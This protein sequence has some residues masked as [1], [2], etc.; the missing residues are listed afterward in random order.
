MTTAELPTS[1]RG[2][3]S[4][5]R[6]L[7]IR[8]SKGRGQNFLHDSGVVNRIVKL[9]GVTHDDTVVEIGP[10]LGILT[11]RLAKAARRV[12]AI[13]ID[14]QLARHLQSSFAATPNVEILR[15]DAMS[16]E[17][18]DVAGN[19]PLR[20]VANLPYS[21]AAAI[22]Q[23][24]LESDA[25]LISATFMLQR[26]VGLRMLAD[27]PNMSILGVATQLYAAGSIGFDVPPD[28]F[29]PQPTV[30]SMVVHLV[31][32]AEPLL[33]R[34]FRPEFFDLVNAGF[35]HKRK[36]IANSLADETGLPK[37]TLNQTLAAAGI[38]PMRRAQT[39]SVT[40]WLTLLD[41]WSARIG[42]IDR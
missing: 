36:N 18:R 7:S 42:R 2:W 27:P 15:A 9:S 23:H 19:G 20:V 17:L 8:P 22:A 3:T 33:E 13:E 25:Q 12:V 11:N 40:E 24:V 26:E 16:I 38:D 21:A 34:E 37:P 39:L 31:P 30:E 14:V 5:I 29:E 35:R 6:E 28:V 1:K 41:E 4:L 10:G 32:H